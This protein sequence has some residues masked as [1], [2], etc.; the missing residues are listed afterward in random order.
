MEHGEIGA[1]VE[2]LEATTFNLRVAGE[3]N[4]P[5]RASRLKLMQGMKLQKAQS[6]SLWTIKQILPQGRLLVMHE[7]QHRND[8]PHVEI[9]GHR[10]LVRVP[11]G[12]L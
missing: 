1:N 11:R 4:H 5:V 9:W 10:R 12:I 3:L 6:D 2:L 7:A 8:E